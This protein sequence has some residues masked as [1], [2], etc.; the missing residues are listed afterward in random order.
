MQCHHPGGIPTTTTTAIVDNNTVKLIRTIT[1]NFRVEHGVK[2]GSKPDNHL[3]RFN[4]IQIPNGEQSWHTDG[5]SR[6][7]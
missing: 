5:Q 6:V 7:T 2:E 4:T 3:S 1:R